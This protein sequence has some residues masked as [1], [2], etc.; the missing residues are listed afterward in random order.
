MIIIDC[1]Q[2]TPE[3]YE[4]RVGRPTASKFSHIMTTKG[5]RS[6]QRDGYMKI[7]AQERIT[8]QMQEAFVSNPMSNGIRNEPKALAVLSMVEEVEI[9]AV[10]FCLSDDRLYGC[11]PDGLIGQEGGCEAKSPEQKTHI[12]YLR[13]GVLPSKYLLQVQGC[14]LVTGRPWWYFISYH[15]SEVP[16][17]LRIPRDE[18]LISKLRHELVCFCRELDDMCAGI[19]K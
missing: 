2:R 13:R 9:T 14:M 18:I 4:A 16:L 5:A 17:I 6:G 12:E 15:E 10:G 8:G 11:S 19:N 7:L 3:W 1:D